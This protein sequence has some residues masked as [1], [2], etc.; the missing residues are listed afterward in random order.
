MKTTTI[1]LAAGLLVAALAGP[2]ALAAPADVAHP[3]ILWTPAEAARLRETFEREAWARDS[4]ERLAAQPKSRA[5]VDLFRAAV[6]GDEKAAKSERD[7]LLTFIDAPLERRDASGRGI[8]KHYDNYLHALRYD[9]FYETLTPAQ[10]EGLERTFRRFVQYEL[11]HPY[12]NTRLSL[13]PNMQLP[14]MFAAHLMSVALQD[15]VL[16]RH[17]WAE[18]SG[19]KWYFDEYLSDGGFYNE[20][21]GKMTSLIGELLLY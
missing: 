2:T 3:Y 6:L 12:R 18:P 15:E 21:F 5:F 11:D 10:R 8:G 16:I 7:Y 17:L 19:F 9:L 13:L 14:R 4:L 20:E 1:A